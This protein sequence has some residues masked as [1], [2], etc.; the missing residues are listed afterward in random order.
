MD[1][2]KKT[3]KMTLA[4]DKNVGKEYIEILLTAKSL[5][6]KPKAESKCKDINKVY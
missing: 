4:V 2:W 1:K 5:N 6:Q 3:A